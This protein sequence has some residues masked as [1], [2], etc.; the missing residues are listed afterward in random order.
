MRNQDELTSGELQL[1]K[2]VHNSLAVRWGTSAPFHIGWIE[3]EKIGFAGIP[4][5]V[6]NVFCR[7]ED[8]GSLVPI[9]RQRVYTELGSRGW[10]PD[11]IEFTPTTQR[12]RRRKFTDTNESSETRGREKFGILY[13]F[14]FE[15]ERELA[16]AT[17]QGS[18]SFKKL[19][20]KEQA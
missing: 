16:H 13:R 19:P 7:D 10:G 4:S 8:L 9:V 2:S 6:C 18:G 3:A 17:F 1:L 14:S 20:T 5:V 12:G 15:M 11:D